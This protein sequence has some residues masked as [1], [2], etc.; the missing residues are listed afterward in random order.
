[1]HKHSFFKIPIDMAT[2]EELQQQ[3]AEL[4]EKMKAFVAKLKDD[5]S[6]EV[7][8]LQSHHQV[9]F[10]PL[11]YWK[12]IHYQWIIYHL[13]NIIC[14]NNFPSI[15]WLHFQEKL[16]QAKILFNRMKE[17]KE[18]LQRQIN[19]DASIINN[20]KLE[21]DACKVNSSN[22]FL[23]FLGH[24]VRLKRHKLQSSI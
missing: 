18:I 24:E 11:W 17:E 20:M 10:L 2:V 5:H 1:M 23:F 7:A 21:L 19:E 13:N 16:E 6:K 9:W 15:I 8:S 22:R 4:K 3:N 12:G 14:S